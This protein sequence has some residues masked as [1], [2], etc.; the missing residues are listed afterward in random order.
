[1]PIGAVTR[2]PSPQGVDFRVR[3]AMVGVAMNIEF[4]TRF[5]VVLAIY[6]LFETLDWAVLSSLEE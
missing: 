5:E 4:E 6:L 1:M 3:R 2:C